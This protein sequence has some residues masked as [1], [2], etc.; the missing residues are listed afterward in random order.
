MA[1]SIWDEV[2]AEAKTSPKASIW[3]EVESE[4]LSTPSI[5]EDIVKQS[6]VGFAKGLGGTY[7]SL[8][9]LTRTNPKEHLLPSQKLR[10]QQESTGTEQDLI[11]NSTNE[12]LMPEGSGRTPTHEDIGNLLEMLGINTKPKTIPGSI[13]QKATEATGSAL[14]LPATAMQAT[15]ATLGGATG[16]SLREAHAPEWMAMAAEAGVNF[17]DLGKKLLT[18]PKIALKKESGLSARGLEKLEK[19]TEVFSGTKEKAI[20]SISNEYK[21][22]T[23]NLQKSTNSS[24]TNFREDPSFQKNLSSAFDK[25]NQDASNLTRKVPAKT[26]QKSLVQDF[27]KT[28]S[29]GFEELEVESKLK[30]NLLKS[31]TEQ[32]GKDFSLSELIDQYRK[33]NSDL[34]HYLPFGEKAVE[35]T[36]KRDLLLAKNRAISTTID[37]HFGDLPEGKAFKDLNKQWSE[38]EK[39]KTVDKFVNSVIKDDKLNPRALKRALDPS[40]KTSRVVE[41]AIGKENVVQFRKLQE[42]MLDMDKGLALMKAKGI[43]LDEVGNH[44]KAALFLPK[45]TGLYWI[46][47]SIAKIYRRGLADPSFRRDWHTHV[48]QF[49]SGDA[50]K[51]VTNLTRLFENFSEKD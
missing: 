42:D 35:N 1:N 29:K 12:D 31:I 17:A 28:G 49:R 16:Q 26:Y 51:A 39:I 32:H 11:R 44:V 21:N 14:S 33:N 41:Q 48:K 3:D 20:E 9:E 8:R 19:P 24:L 50:K 10:A 34:K 45:V 25:L 4:S 37:K 30:D 22:I 23:E 15:L 47:K 2:E 46:G 6:A 7:G 43:P 40:T 27:H 5:P 18:I 36:A 13:A 38:V